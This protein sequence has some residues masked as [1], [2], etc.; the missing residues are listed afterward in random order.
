MPLWANGEGL[1]GRRAVAVRFGK[2]N[3]GGR[4]GDDNG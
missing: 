3:A 4:V 1:R 2:E